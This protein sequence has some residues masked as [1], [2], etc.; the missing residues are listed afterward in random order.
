MKLTRIVLTDMNAQ[1]A[2]GNTPLHLTVDEDSF[3]AMD[4]LLSTY[5]KSNENIS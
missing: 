4:Y 3:D 5:V 1:D 2:T